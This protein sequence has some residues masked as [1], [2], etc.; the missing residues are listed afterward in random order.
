MK[1]TKKGMAQALL[2]GIAV[3]A[4]QQASA[5]QTRRVQQCSE[6]SCPGQGDPIFPEYGT[7]RLSD[8][9]YV[10]P[11]GVLSS[12]RYYNSSQRSLRSTPSS[13]VLP[14]N[15]NPGQGRLA[16]TRSLPR[17]TDDG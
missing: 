4:C 13:G 15:T 14:L 9:D 8:A 1:S 6:G 3:L 11:R 12:E 10:D 16:Y 17:V 5:Q 7:Y 2:L